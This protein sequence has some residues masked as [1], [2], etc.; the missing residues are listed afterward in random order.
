M[1]SKIQE[2]YGIN[3]T[4]LNKECVN[5]SLIPIY[6]HSNHFISK[7]GKV[8]DIKVDEYQNIHFVEKPIHSYTKKRNIPIY[9]LV[10]DITE[11]RDDIR[12]DYL[13]M[14]TMYGPMPRESI[15]Y[16]YNKNWNDVDI[17][18]MHYYINTY[19]VLDN[20]TLLINGITFKRYTRINENIF[21]SDGGVVF[22]SDTKIFKRKLFD[23]KL[24]SYY[25]FNSKDKSVRIGTHRLVYIVW[26]NN[27]LPIPDNMQID[28]M[29][30]FKNHNWVDNLRMVTNLEN[31]R[32]AAYDQGLRSTPW[33]PEI[34]EF[35][36]QQLEDSSVTGIS[37]ILNRVKSKFGDINITYDALKRKIYEIINKEFW[38]DISSKYDVD[39]YRKNMNAHNN[40]AVSDEVIHKICKAKL[41]NTYSTNKELAKSI[42][43][44]EFIVNRVLRGQYREDIS[45]QYDIAY[46]TKKRI[47]FNNEE[48]HQI[49][50]D[51]MNG[52]S[53]SQISKK[54]NRSITDIK[55][56]LRRERYPEIGE[57]YNF[58]KVRLKA[59]YLIPYKY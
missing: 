43:V 10:N 27:N 15:H 35:I 32:S 55:K 3:S 33:S 41:E 20:D 57:K 18:D 46:N 53:N 9:S 58:E 50:Q 22:F 40:V 47:P 29:D 21:V 39:V 34:I 24:Y 14:C 49:C 44:S 17:S 19:E 26:K 5:N 30:G 7:D 56:I 13:Y 11:K 2:K 25:S 36:C 31:F 4:K 54:Y 12:L 48:V 45:S 28:H 52:L 42:G 1:L 59:N 37:D 23:G 16:S 38:T 6:M 8:Y 51:I